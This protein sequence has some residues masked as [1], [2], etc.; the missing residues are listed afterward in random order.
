M[1]IFLLRGD[2]TRDARLSDFFFFSLSFSL[3]FLRGDLFSEMLDRRG[4]L[5]RFPFSFMSL[6][7]RLRLWGDLPLCPFSS[8]VLGD[9]TFLA[10]SSLFASFFLIFSSMAASSAS[11]FFFSSSC[12]RRRS[13]RRRR[14]SSSRVRRSSSRRFT[15]SSRLCFF[16]N[17]CRFT[18]SCLALAFS[19]SSLR[20]RS[21][22][23]FESRLLPLLLLPLPLSLRLLRRFC[24]FSSHSFRS[25]SILS[26][27]P[28]SM[29]SFFTTLRSIRLMLAT[30]GARTRNAR[31]THTH[32]K[33]QTPHLCK[34]YAGEN[35]RKCSSCTARK[36]TMK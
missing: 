23:F 14:R 2:A 17:S 5:V 27:S 4:D 8:S 7:G 9:L 11:F 16:S 25:F 6:Q 26:A 31:H 28:V 35:K 21:F 36:A 33:S 10:G 12:A 19:S 1:E 13:S 29:S 18:C 15:S 24:W 30:W 32:T 20:R 3:S 22:S 34:N